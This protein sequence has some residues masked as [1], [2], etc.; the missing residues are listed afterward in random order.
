VTAKGYVIASALLTAA[1][2]GGYLAWRLSAPAVP[3]VATDGMDAEVAALIAEAR[4]DVTAQPRSAAAWGR[5][6]MVL[7]GNTLYGESIAV[8][9]QAEKLDPNDPRWPYLCGLA[10]ILQRPQEGL[11]ALK[12]AAAV[13]RNAHPFALRLAEESLKQ[14]RLDEADELFG[15]T[16]A[17]PAAARAFLGQ[18][19]ILLQRGQPQAAIVLLEQ[20]ALDP[21]AQRVARAALAEAYQRLG[22]SAD[23]D[24][25]RKRAQALPPDRPWPDPILSETDALHTGLQYR[26]DRAVGLLDAGQVDQARALLNEVLR[27]HP[28]SDDA[29][30]AMG[31]V[32]M[33]TG[34]VDEAAKHLQ[35]A[36]A[37]NPDMVEA[38]F[39]LGA[40]QMAKTDYAAAE[41]SFRRAV[42]LKPSYGEAYYNLG[43]CRLRQG[44]R[45]G[46]REALAEAVRCLPDLVP[47]HLEFGALLLEDGQV[48]QAITHLEQAIR[49]DAQ[50]QRA[51]TLLEKARQSG[52]TGAK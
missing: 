38:H 12:R 2:V 49:L 14:D 52:E 19:Q 51:R 40:V 13:S 41:A 50:N 42:D 10:L 31:K 47:A 16:L 43:T 6:G 26:V 15:E 24:A 4:A 45:T 28:N 36:I 5:L 39:R 34:A 21:M 11:D 35:H 23:A 8:L 37:L 9:A 1:V 44:N 20:A 48:Q 22:R 27:D 46:A 30:L 18:G 25:E 3:L 7:F 33:Q 32:W 29:E 17:G